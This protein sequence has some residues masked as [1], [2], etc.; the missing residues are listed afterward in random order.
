VARQLD[1]R[2][3]PQGV[4]L[5]TNPNLVAAFTVAPAAPQAGQSVTFDASTSTNGG[6]ACA[7]ACSYAWDFGDGTT[8]AGITTTHAYR[9]AANYAAK[10]TVTDARGAQ[11]AVAQTVSVASP[12]PPTGTI[13]VSPTPPI[14]TNSDVF[15]SAA[16]IQWSGRTITGYDWN[17]GDGT[18]G[19]GV[20]TTHRFGGVGTFNVVLTVTDASG[21]QASL[22]ISVQITAQGGAAAQLTVTPASPRV[23]QQAS[24]DASASTPSTGATIVSY[25]FN[26]GD[27]TEE[28][29]SNPVQSHAFG[30]A[31][32]VIVS[33]EITDSNGKTSTKTASVTITP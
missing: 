21:A 23:G 15:F 9:T 1:I 20:T 24:F 12:T 32:T 8:G 6:S 3:Q 33:V 25:K 19:S 17:F 18:R 29:V 7:Q 16:A 2:L 28:V 14:G 22:N 11:A 4:I 31:G 27:G 30:A 10:L 26:Y 13:V 5:P